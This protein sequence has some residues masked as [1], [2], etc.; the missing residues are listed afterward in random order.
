MGRTDVLPK[1]GSSKD[2]LLSDPLSNLNEDEEAE[3]LEQIL[4]TASFEEFATK[5]VQYD[6][7]IWVMISLLLVLAWG[8][9]LIMLLCLPIR[10]CILKKEISSRKLYVTPHEIVYKAS[11]PSFIPF[12]GMVMIEKHVPLPQVIDII[13]E[14]GCLQSVYGIHT[15]RVESIAQGKAAPVD[16]L[17]VQGVYNPGLLRKIIVT[18][19]AKAIQE[20]DRSW[21]HTSQISEGEST[22]RVGSF[23]DGSA[24]LRSPVKTSKIGSS[25]RHASIEHRGVVSADLFLHKLDEVNKSVKKIELLIEQSHASSDRS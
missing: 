18:E 5:F 21:K 1:L 24:I 4:Y 11:R 19:A 13:I 23:S 7:I 16:E 25:P 22:V 20:F 14:Q 3:Y 10:R 17:Q 2:L 9:G 12:W 6:T 15:F 8:I